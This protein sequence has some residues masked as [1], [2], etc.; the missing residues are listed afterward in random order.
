MS[1]RS[2]RSSCRSLIFSLLPILDVSAC[3]VPLNDRTGFVAEGLGTNQKPSI[4]PIITANTHLPFTRFSR[5][6]TLPPVWEKTRSGHCPEEEI[7]ALRTLTI[8][9]AREVLRRI[10]ASLNICAD[11][12]PIAGCRVDLYAASLS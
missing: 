10:P 9:Q 5:G 7:I 12:E 6:P 8:N 2:S 3:S 11:C 1:C 4:D